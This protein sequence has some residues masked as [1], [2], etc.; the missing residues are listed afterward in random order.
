MLQLPMQSLFIACLSMYPPARAARCAVPEKTH[1]PCWSLPCNR[2]LS[3][4]CSYLFGRHIELCPKKRILYVGAS[5][6]TAVYCMLVTT[7]S[8][9]ALHC[10]RRNASCMLAL[11]LQPQF[12]ACLS[13]PVRVARC[14]LPEKTHPPSWSSPHDRRLSCA[15]S[16]LFGQRTTMCPKKRTLHVAA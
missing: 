1:S 9:S 11:P 14:A 13:S 16:H 10:T 4:A 5:E 6:K 2:R 15:C 3:H 7:C 12:I 8:G